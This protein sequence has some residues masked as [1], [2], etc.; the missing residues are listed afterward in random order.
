MLIL[1]NEILEKIVKSD[2]SLDDYH[3]L[4]C[5]A[6]QYSSPYPI[7]VETL[8][9][10]QTKGFLE[11][12]KKDKLTLHGIKLIFGEESI[13]IFDPQ[14]LKDFKEWWKHFPTTDQHGSYPKRFI[15][16]IQEENC[17]A[18]YRQARIKH[19]LKAE[20]LLIPM[21]EEVR[22]RIVESTVENKLSFMKTSIDWLTKEEFLHY[23]TPE[24]N[25]KTLYNKDLS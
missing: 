25:K 16:R 1:D 13:D 8:L 18:A 15:K 14:I 5:V 9:R 22:T 24:D 7:K 21:Q 20:D 17:Y 12:N 11:P 4:W 3:A 19:N 6:N 2:L 10:L 23:K